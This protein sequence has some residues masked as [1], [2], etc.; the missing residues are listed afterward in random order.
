MKVLQAASSLYDWGGIERY[1]FYLS[2][3]LASQ[4]I[5]NAVACPP[6]SPLAKHL[7]SSAI[8]IA[9]K[10]RLSPAVIGKY[11]T[12]LRAGKYDVI[13]A[14]FSPDFLAAGIAG[15][16]AKTQLR[17][18]TRHVALPM[19]PNKIKRNLAMF[20]HIIPVSDAVMKVLKQSGVPPHKMTV[21]KAGV[22]TLV[23]TKPRDE[24]REQ[25]GL[26]ED[27]FAVGCF[28]RLVE[29]K[30]IA[31]LI[32][33]AALTQGVKYHIFGDGPEKQALNRMVTEKNLGETVKIHGFVPEVEN[34]MNAMDAIA[35]PSTWAEAFPYAA[36]EALS[37]GVPVIA[38]KIGGLPELVR[39]GVNGLLFA[40][41]DV[42]GFITNVMILKADRSLG[43]GL[44][45]TGREIHQQRY[46]VE[47]MGE[48]I[49]NVYKHELGFKGYIFE[50]AQ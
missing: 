32:K 31:T 8:P 38:S 16:L 21:A 26:G 37:I 47:K 28:G 30:G 22:P 9:L 39:D 13:H 5:E 3:G 44:G 29:E 49:A 50:L 15:R 6:G 1:A 34:L 19:P 41:G 24:V 40:A 42:E 12:T 2:Q 25:L 43:P 17:I 45:E 48:R 14:H 20:E 18:M 33:A 11:L 46:T 35:I 23:A 7:G 36:L 10:G 4:G 27:D